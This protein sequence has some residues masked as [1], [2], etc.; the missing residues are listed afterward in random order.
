MGRVPLVP[1]IG[2]RLVLREG[3]VIGALGVSGA[4]PEQDVECADAALR[5]LGHLS[6]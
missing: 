5:A 4:K 3:R 1:G 2:G 6:A